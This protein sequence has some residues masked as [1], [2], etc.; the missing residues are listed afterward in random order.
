VFRKFRLYY[1]ACAQGFKDDVVQA[2][3]WVLEKP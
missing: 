1:W 2:Y 3:H